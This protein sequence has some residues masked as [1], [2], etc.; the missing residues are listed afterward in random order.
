MLK[1]PNLRRQS[2]GTPRGVGVGRSA[3]GWTLRL[4]LKGLVVDIPS[5]HTKGRILIT[6]RAIRSKNDEGLKTSSAGLM[7]NEK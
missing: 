5:L 6:C 4:S 1:Q 2:T 7:P 3:E